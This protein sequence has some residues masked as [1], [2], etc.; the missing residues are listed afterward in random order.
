MFVL[1]LFGGRG[2]PCLYEVLWI[3][4]AILFCINSLPTFGC[5]DLLLSK[6]SVGYPV[7]LWSQTLCCWLR[8][9]S[10]KSDFERL[11]NAWMWGF[12]EISMNWGA[13]LR[14]SAMKDAATNAKLR[15]SVLLKR[16]PKSTTAVLGIKGA[17]CLFKWLCV[18]RCAKRIFGRVW[19]NWAVRF[20]IVHS[21]CWRTWI[22]SLAVSLAV[23]VWKEVTLCFEEHYLAKVLSY[24]I[25]LQNIYFH[26]ANPFFLF[27]FSS[28]LFI[29]NTFPLHLQFMY[30]LFPAQTSE[31]R[32]R[33][34]L[35]S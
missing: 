34:M 25:V 23:W 12:P 3:V 8:M 27:L 35:F 26:T 22:V 28:A 10:D 16:V 19:R 7:P 9:M 15:T 30:F 29:S 6:L 13:A 24:L 1:G 21:M 14:T 17:Y 31:C 2:T 5:G 32:F 11:D 33:R 4:D 20:D 18:L